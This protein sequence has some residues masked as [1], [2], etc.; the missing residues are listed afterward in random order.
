MSEDYPDAQ[1]RVTAAQR[2]HAAAELREAAADERIDFDELEARL[3]AAL[4]AK[5]RG[6][7]I[8][9]LR[10]LVPAARMDAVVGVEMPLGSGVG[11]SWEN[12]WVLQGV[13]WEAVKLIGEWQ[14]P[15]FM[16]LVDTGAGIH[17]NAT[18]ATPLA[19][20]I[21]I[22]ITGKGRVVLVV[23]EGWGVDVTQLTADA[24]QVSGMSSTVR[25]RPERG[26]PRMV[27]RGSFGGTVAVRHPG[28]WDRRAM[29]K[30]EKQGRPA[31]V[32]QLPAP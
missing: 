31:P 1:L 18:L 15:P 10:D 23:P 24:G 5:T 26:Q 27:L 12:P 8:A 21:D 28:W 19:P 7:L 2:D 3:P 17:L 4:T 22:V 16:E 30:W 29:A 25:S 14:I 11:F 13:G 20:V 6:D 9:V 32:A